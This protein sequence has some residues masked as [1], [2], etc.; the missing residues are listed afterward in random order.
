MAEYLGESEPRNSMEITPCKRL[1]ARD[2]MQEIFWGGGGAVK[3]YLGVGTRESRGRFRETERDRGQERTGETKRG[4]EDL[5]KGI[6]F[7]DDITESP[8]AG[9]RTAWL[10]TEELKEVCPMASATGGRVQ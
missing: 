6:V 4:G 7:G 5:L 3:G 2:F 1:H 8:N 9:W 10:L